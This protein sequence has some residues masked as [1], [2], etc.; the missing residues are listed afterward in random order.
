MRNVMTLTPLL[1]TTP[2]QMAAAL[3]VLEDA[4]SD[5]TDYRRKLDPMFGVARIVMYEC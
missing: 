3:V 2:A 4:I 1:A 5:R